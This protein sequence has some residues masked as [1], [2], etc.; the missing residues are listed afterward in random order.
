M[1]THAHTH[2]HTHTHAHT[3]T[4]S[5]HLVLDFLELRGYRWASYK[6]NVSIFFKTQGNIHCMFL[7][8]LNHEVEI[9]ELVGG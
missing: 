3:H 2:M 7:V 6:V 4:Q 9:L 8:Q 1:H 5:N